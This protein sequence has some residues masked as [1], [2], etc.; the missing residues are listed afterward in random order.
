[1]KN[2]QPAE[3]PSA[4]QF[5]PLDDHDC[6]LFLDFDGTLVD[7]AA[8]PD[9]V[10]IPFE[11]IASL[12]AVHTLLEGRL[13]IVT[14]RQI[15][16]I[17]AM[18]APLILP[19]AGVHGMERRNAEGVTHYF[20]YPDDHFAT[21]F[22]ALET[23]AVQLAAIH[24]GVI[25]EQKRGAVALHYRQAPALEALCKTAMQAALGTYPG[26]VLLFG[27]MV[28]EAKPANVTK[29]TAIR[30]FLAEPPFVGARPVFA[31]DDTTDEA[32]FDYVQQVGGIGVKIGKGASVAHARVASPQ[33]LR[34][35]LSR[36]VQQA[37][38][39]HPADTLPF[40]KGS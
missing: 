24:P 9:E 35:E 27:K 20:A 5:F 30:D 23:C 29:G 1:M 15:A 38:Q 2:A 32:G 34:A 28:I 36:W 6:A 14:G 31:G 33:A 21:V 13:A 37:Q 22:S 10:V 18:L 39:A 26:I 12:R 7:L 3:A 40:A 8:R 25:V 4:E 17:D 16:Q 11:L 19:V